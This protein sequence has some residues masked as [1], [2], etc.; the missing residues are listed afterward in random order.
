MRG[1]LAQLS[2]H[3][4]TTLRKIGFGSGDPLEAQHVHRLLQL[5]LI[6]WNGSRWTLTELGRRRYDSLVC[7]YKES[8]KVA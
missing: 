1:M 4:E 2:P 3:E 8:V 5:E 7:I 6:E